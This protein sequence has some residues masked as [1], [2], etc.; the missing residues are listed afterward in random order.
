VIIVRL[1]LIQ[2]NNTKDVITSLDIEVLGINFIS[3]VRRMQLVGLP[4]LLRH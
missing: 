1:G 2:N 3:L 4:F